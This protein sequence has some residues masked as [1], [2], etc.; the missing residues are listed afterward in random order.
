MTSRFAGPLAFVDT[1]AFFALLDA[2]DQYHGAA[3]AIQRRLVAEHY[4]LVTSN[5]ILVETHALLL[6]KLGR[7][8]ALRF[9]EEMEISALRLV[10]VSQSDERE[11]MRLLQKY[12]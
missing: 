10:R 12:A 9:L 7:V 1:S 2:R 4:G 11:G 5:L 6:S 3:V 8:I